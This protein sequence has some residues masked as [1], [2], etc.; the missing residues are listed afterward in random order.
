MEKIAVFV[1]DTAHAQHLLQP[2][3]NSEGPVHWIL[4]ACPPTLSR[5]IGRW[6]TQGAREQWRQRWAA[7]CF[8]RL[9]ADIKV[10]PRNRIE[11]ILAS[12]SPSDMAKRLE[13]R[14]GSLKLLDARRPLLGKPEEPLTVSQPPSQTGGWSLPIAATTG[15]SAMLALAD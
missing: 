13:A 1:N 10:D 11:K 8:A 14:L 7:E 6:V 4:V 3:L 2:L 12:R 5:H 15:L 9:E